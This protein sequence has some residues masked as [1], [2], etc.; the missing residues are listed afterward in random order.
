MSQSTTER[1]ENPET[2]NQSEY[3][4]AN[5]RERFGYDSPLDELVREGARRMLQAA[6]DA[7]VD[8]FIESHY[9]RRDEQGRRLVVRNGSLPARDSD[10]SRPAGGAARTRA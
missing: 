7:E 9:D 6:V 8:E 10:G 2:S 3:E 4:V 5:F 1:I